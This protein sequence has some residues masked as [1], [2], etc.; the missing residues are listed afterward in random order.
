MELNRLLSIY[1][2]LGC[3]KVY[4]KTLADNDNSKNQVYLAGSFEVLNILPLKEIKADTG[5]ERKRETFKSSLDFYWVQEDGRKSHAPHAQLILYPDYPEIRLSGFLKGSKEAPSELM[6]SRLK[7]RL[8]FLGVGKGTET[9]AFI[10]APDSQLANEFAA[11]GDVPVV[12]LLKELTLQNRKLELDSKGKLL[13]ELTRIHKLGWIK[14]K[15]LD[16]KSNI[17]PCL[18][19]NCGGYTLEAELGITPNGYAEPDFLG[20]EVKQFKVKDF[21]KFSSEVITLMTPEPSQG[22]YKDQ[23]VEAF[24]MKYGYDDKKGR[25]N[26][27]NFGGIYKYNDQHASTGLKLVV[28]GFDTLSNKITR[29]DGYIGL[30]DQSG[31]IAA[32]WAFTSLL[33]HW[34]KKHANACYVPARVDKGNGGQQYW[35]GNNI[36]LGSGTDFPLVLAQMIKGNVYYDPAVKL[37][38]AI[39]GVRKQAIKRRSQFRIK[40]GELNTL[41]KKNE[42]VD[43]TK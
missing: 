21:K 10:T 29:P 15:R 42:I 16:S 28:N 22:Y 39:A 13:A 38:F 12:G 35:F 2:D 31:D 3:N 18:S 1:S 17:L 20:W 6:T 37:E 25:E 43:V 40:S 11:L 4:V 33:E 5:G 7:G 14:S 32:G 23:G 8:L 26:R 34:N 36:I 9:Y 41:Y 19:P 27:R 30:I 24:I